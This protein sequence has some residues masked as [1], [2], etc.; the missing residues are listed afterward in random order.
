MANTHQ[1]QHVDARQGAVKAQPKSKNHVVRGEV[2]AEQMMQSPETMRAEDVLAAQQT[3]GNQVVQRALDKEDRRKGLTDEQGNLSQEITSQ[4]QQKR[5]GGSPLPENIQKEASKKLGRNFKDVRIHTDEAADTLSR[6]I[7]ARAF[8]IGKDIFFKNGVFSPGSGAGRET[9]IHELTHVVQQGGKGGASGALKLGAPDTT[10]EKEADRIG[11]KHAASIG[12]APAGAVQREGEEDELMMQEDE[13]E[14]QMQE[15]DDIAED[16]PAESPEDLMMQEDEEELQ[17]QEDDD[18]AEDA[19]AESPEDLMMQE[20]E[21]ELQMQPAEEDELQMQPDAGNVIQRKWEQDENG[22]WKKKDEAPKGKGKKP[23]VPPLN[24]SKLKPKAPKPPKGLPPVPKSVKSTVKSKAKF[25]SLEEATSTEA[26]EKRQEK[27]GLMEHDRDYQAKGRLKE[28]QKAGKMSFLGASVKNKTDQEE[29]A[30]DPKQVAKQKWMA[31]LKDPKASK[32]DIEKAKERLGTF[33]KDVG[34]K[35]FKAAKNERRSALEE[36]AKSGDDEAYEKWQ[37]E[38]KKTKGEKAKGFFKSA[39]KKVGS[40]LL[41]AGK[42]AG[43]KGLGFA[44]GKLNEGVNHF[45]GIKDDDKD[46]DDDKAPKVN[47][48]NNI[49]GG[50]SGGGSTEML[51]ELYQENKKLKAQIAELEKAKV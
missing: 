22:K 15:D 42:W 29:A 51:T 20:D 40:G 19:P 24:F 25:A 48:T 35:D 45:L 33:H 39:G 18:I 34:K 37:S 36:S 46:D 50:S 26:S 30:K 49:G 1:T 43:K 10:H 2:N 47:V 8:T 16:A 3:V 41:S 28:E 32:E 23:V 7:S 6:T 14:L 44:K 4:I 12:A 11:K 9:I 38:R 17:M 5:G 27:I 21:D 31:T 13:E